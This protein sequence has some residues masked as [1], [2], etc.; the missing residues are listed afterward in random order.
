VEAR[1]HVRAAKK[2]LHMV[3]AHASAMPTPTTAL[4]T[5]VI[6]KEYSIRLLPE[7]SRHR[8]KNFLKATIFNRKRRPPV[9]NSTDRLSER[10]T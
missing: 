8:R 3:V 1:R 6:S 7:Q 4:A 2:F 9:E 10:G 5:V